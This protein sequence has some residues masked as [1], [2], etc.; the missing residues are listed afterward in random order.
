MN[1]REFLGKMS[2]GGAA[3]ALAGCATSPSGHPDDA[4]KNV[5]AESPEAQ[6]RK[7]DALKAAKELGPTITDVEVRRTRNIPGKRAALYIDDVIFVFRDLA[8]QRP[9]SCWNHFFLA[10][11]KE[12]HEKYGLKVQLN[13]FYRNDFYYGARGAEFT[14][15]EMP[16]IWKAE[17]QAAKDWLKFGFHSYSEFPDYPWINAGYD[18]VKFTWNLLAGEV[19]RFAGPGMFAKAVTPHWGPM[20]KEGCVALKDCGATAIWCSGGKR[21]EYTGDRTILPYGHGMRIENFRKPET[22]MFWRPG[23]GD[24]I[25]VSACGYNHLLPDQ[26]KVTYG[27]Y[28]WLYDKATG[29]NF[30][31]FGCGAPCLNLYRLEDIPA[32]MRQVIGSEFLIHATHEEYWYKDYF[33]YQPDSREKLLV[34]CKMVHDAGYK[35]SF[36]EDKI[37]W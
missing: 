26:V 29:C 12:A 33:A 13:I 18:D 25:S 7:M 20:S 24:D 11:L 1:R 34:S 19:E 28:N 16:D 2:V 23:G 36:I 14:I 32:R 22:A 21:Y 27:T 17:F 35:Y 15:K 31:R 5:R 30:M 8:V 3:L 37:D 9:K 10:A 6:A 4:I